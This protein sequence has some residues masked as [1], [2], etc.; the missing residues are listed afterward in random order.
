MPDDRSWIEF[1][2]RPEA[3]FSDGVPLTVD[4]VMFSIELLGTKGRP[5]Y[6]SWYD[7]IAKMEKTGERSVRFTFKERATARSRS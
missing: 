6:R 7:K 1:T 3:K 4:D 2:L 5:N